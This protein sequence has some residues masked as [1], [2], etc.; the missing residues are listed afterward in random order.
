MFGA[1]FNIENPDNPDIKPTAWVLGEDTRSL[2]NFMS[3]GEFTHE[4]LGEV[5]GLIRFAGDALSDPDTFDYIDLN[6]G[7][8]LAAK[9]SMDL[10]KR[11][12]KPLVVT[13][14]NWYASPKN[15][16]TFLAIT[17]NKRI[18]PQHILD[19]SEMRQQ[20]PWVPE[21]A[22]KNACAIAERLGGRLLPKAPIIEIKQARQKLTKEIKRGIKLRE[23]QGLKFTKVY[24]DRLDRELKVIKEKAFESYF[25]VVA[26]LCIWAKQHMLVG[27]ARGSSAGSLVCFLLSITEVDPIVHKLLFERFI[28]LN[29]ADFPDIDIDFSDRRR[30]MVFDYLAQK[31]GEQNVARLG[32]VSSLRSRSVIA[33]CGKRLGI[34]ANDTFAVKNVLIEYSSGD[35]RYGKG[36]EDTLA[37]TKPGGRLHEEVSARRAHDCC[38]EPR[39]AYVGPRRRRTR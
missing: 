3:K 37:N 6:P 35:R 10:H 22:F 38:R 13:S 26:D 12:K 5:S 33:E 31:Y 25:V 19:A 32:N 24:Q 21:S 23:A 9:R 7:S 39:V 36:L 34:P 4:E 20:M 15:R 8:M 18:T 17:D 11:T 28:D 29:R 27:P 16:G 2:Y 14:D 30:Y 1:S